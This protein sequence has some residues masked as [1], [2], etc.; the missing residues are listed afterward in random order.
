VHHS[1]PARRLCALVICILLAG[2][3]NLYAER[4]LYTFSGRVISIDD[5][6]GAL[7]RSHYYRTGDVVSASFIVDL[8]LPGYEILNDGSRLVNTRVTGPEVFVDYFYCRLVS[9]PLM[10]NFHSEWASDPRG[11][12]FYLYGADWCESTGCSTT[13]VGGSAAS[14][15][16]IFSAR[17][18]DG[19]IENWS[20]GLALSGIAFA[21]TDTEESVAGMDMRLDSITPAPDLPP[22]AQ[23]S[24]PQA[25]NIPGLIESTNDTF[26]ILAGR[27][28]HMSVTLNAPSTDDD[29]DP[30]YCE[31][32]ALDRAVPPSV[33]G[34]FGHGDAPVIQLP[35]GTQ[36][37][38]LRARDASSERDREFSVTVY[39][40]AQAT[41]IMRNAVRGMP[42]WSREKTTASVL[43]QNAASSFQRSDW[44]RGVQFLQTF[45]QFMARSAFTIPRSKRSS[46]IDLSRAI[47]RAVAQPL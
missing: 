37:I 26:F 16:S 15:F 46:C 5:P 23:P 47:R 24:V 28:R 40:P 20:E 17:S 21:Y 3:A 25:I 1:N 10:P 44:K 34:F 45:E 36:G 27:T 13:L 9:G 4:F 43:L 41:A 11:A 39:T 33:I 14:A 32:W 18:R 6:S 30:L 2:S 31:W 35:L 19:L 12:R 7:A 22:E 29:G 38:L 8:A 42:L